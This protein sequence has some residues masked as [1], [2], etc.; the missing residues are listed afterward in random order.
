MP[1]SRSLELLAP[2]GDA[3]ALAAALA[4]GAGAVYF[5]LGELNARRKARN[6]TAAELAGVITQVHKAGAKA[7]LTLN[8]DLK[9]RELGTAARL[10]TL[11]AAT[12]VDAVLVRDPA[13]LALRPFFPSLPFHFST[14]AGAASSADARAAQQLGLS[15]V[16]LARECSLDE[17]R[18]ASATGIE[19]EVFVQGALCYCISGRCLL[20]SWGGGRSGNRGACTSPCRV[21]W[22]VGGPAEVAT[23]LS[24]QD[25]GLVDHLRELAGA[26]V[27]CL[28]IEG[29]MKNAGWVGQATALYR[30]ALAAVAGIPFQHRAAALGDYTGRPVSDGYLAS[31]RTR[32]TGTWARA[33][34]VDSAEETEGATAPTPEPPAAKTTYD[35]QIMADPKGFRCSLTCRGEVREWVL[36]L[37]EAEPRRAGRAISIRDYLD[38]LKSEPI[39]GY[40][41]ARCRSDLAYRLLMP[42]VTKEI[43][44][45]IS[46]C[47]HLTLKKPAAAPQKLPLPEAVREALAKPTPHPDNRWALGAAPNRVRLA[48]GQAE[49]FAAAV[50]GVPMVAELA[51]AELLPRLSASCQRRLAIALPS[52]F[53]EEAIPGIEALVRQA[54]ALNLAV[55]V[56][57]WGGWEIARHHSGLRLEAGPGLA[58]F[59]VQA[60]RFLG[61]LGFSAI[62]WTIEADQS[63]LEDLAAACPLP[64]TLMVYGRPALMLSR[65]EQPAETLGKV[66]ED[67]RDIRMIPHHENGLL[68]FRSAT[69]FNLLGERDDRIRAAWLAADLVAA[70]DPI[71]EWNR[72]KRPSPEPRFT[73]NYHRGLA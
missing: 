5:G 16:V 46:K 1:S 34:G 3:A 25:L 50:P 32:L 29:R 23:P 55:E 57:S 45:E 69:P 72:L 70:T 59:N 54:A 35:L 43:S 9:D 48:A 28:K 47:L 73:F 38:S 39:Q 66:W 56:N 65:A 6:F 4:A 60:A 18:A 37:A 12:G 24:M 33:A 27:A 53:F 22:G 42:R 13:L 67:R 68:A 62:H 19:I 44:A 2:A 64:A 58:V 36:P 10:L 31:R 49:A 17:I 21:P 8:I 52:I 61:S 63:M 7:Y 26:G 71:A 15:R 20:S 51:T 40:T 14:Q 30:E 11:A 41:L